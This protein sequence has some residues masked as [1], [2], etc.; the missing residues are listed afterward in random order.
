MQVVFTRV[1]L[2]RIIDLTQAAIREIN[3]S[4]LVTSALL[5]AR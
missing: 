4:A 2:R 5:T 1:A 3:R